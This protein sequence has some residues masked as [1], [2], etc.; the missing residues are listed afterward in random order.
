MR[1][2]ALFSLLLAAILTLGCAG[3]SGNGNSAGTGGAGGMGTGGAGAGG[4]AGVGGRG[5]G[6][7][8]AGTGGSAGSGGTAT[9]TGC[10]SDLTGTWDIIA[11][12]TYASPGSGTLVIGADTLT[13]SVNHGTEGAYRLAYS[14]QG[15]QTLQWQEPSHPAIPIDVLDTPVALDAGSI[16][17]ALGGSWS[18]SANLV[19]F[20]VSVGASASSLIVDRLPTGTVVGGNWPRTIPM[21][22][23]G[24]TYSVTR[25]SQ[26]VS[27][28]GF[29]GG[30]WQATTDRNSDTCLVKVENNAVQFDCQTGNA[31]N[32]TTQLTVGSDCVASGLSNSGYELSARRR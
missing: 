5:S 12:P 19:R 8:S 27:Q 10:A 18:F 16:P 9:N 28:F 32:G 22:R 7:S 17:L 13:V 1:Q 25:R 11:T 4:V 6:G 21:P 23:L 2:H 29:F 26:L 24:E 15:G 3:G 30:Q 14:T 20:S 31:F